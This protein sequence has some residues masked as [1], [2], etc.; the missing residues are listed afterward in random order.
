MAPT[1][2]FTLSMRVLRSGLCSSVM[3][4]GLL[5]RVALGNRRAAAVRPRVNHGSGG[6]MWEKS[7]RQKPYWRPPTGHF[8]PKDRKFLPRIVVNFAGCCSP[9]NEKRREAFASP[10]LE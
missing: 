8:L 7:T 1:L 9:V 10:A 3:L 5:S 2:V 4:A 6:G